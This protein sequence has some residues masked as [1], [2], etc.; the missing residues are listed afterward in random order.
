MILHKM[1]VKAQAWRPVQL[2]GSAKS[3]VGGVLSSAAARTGNAGQADYAAANE[4][5]NR[6]AHYT[7]QRF[8][9]MCVRSIGWGP[10]EGGMVSPE[11]ARHFASRGV[12]RFHLRWSRA[13]VREL[14]DES[15]AEVAIGADSDWIGQ[16]IETVVWSIT[17]RQ[18]IFSRTHISRYVLVP[19]AVVVSTFRRVAEQLGQGTRLNKLNVFNPVHI[20]DGLTIQYTINS[21]RLQLM[22]A[23]GKPLYGIQLDCIQ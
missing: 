9:H 22:S 23:A 19:M 4:V 17:T 14:T 18:K 11:L 21:G 16:S 8:P 6:V 2:V 7:K 5:L 3:Q 10:W 1:D 12:G 20:Q 15:H 13:F